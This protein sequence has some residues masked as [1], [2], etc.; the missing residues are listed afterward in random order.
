MRT[1]AAIA[2]LLSFAAPLA[3]C[4]DGPGATGDVATYDVLKAARD[5]CA[6]KGGELTLKR[7]GLATKLSAYD[8]VRK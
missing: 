2:L 8:C 3:A 6:A 1:F 4:A 7:D 5:D